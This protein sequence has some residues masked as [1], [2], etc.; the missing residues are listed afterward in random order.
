MTLEAPLLRSAPDKHRIR[1]IR[2]KFQSHLWVVRFSRH[3]NQQ[4][5][6]ERV[7]V[8]RRTI[9]RIENGKTTP[10]VELAIRLAKA[11][12]VSVDA[13]FRID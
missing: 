7:G 1:R 11:L 5:L 10:S 12:D 4:E 2:N 13:I 8:N 6:A 9:C 3:M